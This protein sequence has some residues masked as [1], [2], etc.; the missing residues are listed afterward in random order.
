MPVVG[1]PRQRVNPALYLPE[2]AA[3]LRCMCV[4]S[5]TV[6]AP[7]ANPLLVQTGRQALSLV[8]Q[9]LRARG[10]TSLIEPD[11]HC[12]TMIEPFS[13]EGLHIE[14]V[15]CGTDGHMTPAGLRHA[16]EVD[17]VHEAVLYALT[18]AQRPSAEMERLLKEI[19]ERGGVL[20]LD[21]THLPQAAL[22]PGPWEYRMVSLRKMLPVPDGAAVW[23]LDPSRAREIGAPSEV[24]TRAGEALMHARAAELAGLVEQ[25]DVLAAEDAFEEAVEAAF[26]Q[27]TGEYAMTAP[28][29]SATRVANRFLCALP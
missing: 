12:T 10:L 29:I 24:V 21:A 6:P 15:E 5:G 17:G 26:S 11:V 4:S 22:D 14:F 16:V 28:S 27:P 3:K 13:R 7:P 2:L 8:A 1:S 20:I 9:D 23:G 18:S 19:A 25:Q